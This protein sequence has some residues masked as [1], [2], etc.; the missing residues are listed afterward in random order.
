M[1]DSDGEMTN[2][3]SKKP[4][5]EFSIDEAL[6]SIQS[7]GIAEFV[8]QKEQMNFKLEDL[9]R[10]LELVVRGQEDSQRYLGCLA[11][12]KLLSRTDDPPYLKT[13]QA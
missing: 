11:L 4:V 7:V 3:Q 9:P 12:R 8:A 10:V 1:E 13:V 5:I 6:T 2:S